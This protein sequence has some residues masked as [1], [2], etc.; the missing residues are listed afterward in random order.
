MAQT[1]EILSRRTGSMKSIRGIVHTMKTLSVINSA[2]YEHA[3]RA[4]EAYHDTVLIGLQGFLHHCGPLDVSSPNIAARVL[5]VFGSD[6]GLCGNYNEVLAAYV[7]ASL[8][9]Q[10]DHPVTLLCVGAQMAD[11]LTDQGLDAEKTFFPPASVDGIGRLSNLLTQHVDGIRYAATPRDMSVSLAYFA[12]DGV[13]N[14]VGSQKPVISVLL[15]LDPT[16]VRDLET[17]P[18]ASRTVPSFTM[19]PDDLFMALIRSHLFASMFRAA[20]EALVTEN[21]ARLALMQ[22][23]EQSVDDRLEALTSETRSVRQNEITTELLDVI[24]GFEALRKGKT[25]RVDAEKDQKV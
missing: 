22:Q 11:A 18:W 19:P 14:A 12:R 25:K 10:P 1:L 21:A 9:A 16:L 3:A 6:H 15:P 17:K 13:P 2:P 20:A 8:K 7:A 24:T 5:I 23:A 4:I